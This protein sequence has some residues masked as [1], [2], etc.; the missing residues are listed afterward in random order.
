MELGGQKGL[1]CTYHLVSITGRTVYQRPQQKNHQEGA[2]NYM[3]QQEED[4]HCVC[5]K[6]SN[7]P[8]PQPMRNCPSPKLILF[9]DCMFSHT[10]LIL[11]SNYCCSVTKS[12]PA[13]F[14]PMDYSEPGFP[15]LHYLIHPSQCPPFPYKM[16]FLPFVYW[17]YIWLWLQL[18]CPELQF[19]LYSQIN[20]FLCIE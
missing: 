14:D 6:K 18:A 20:L 4:R 2:S 9:S 8:A 15:V 1:S 13:L 3:C 10:V 17:T 5:E 11:F 7:T 12:C 19:L 16:T